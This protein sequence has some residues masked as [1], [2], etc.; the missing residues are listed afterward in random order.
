MAL[1][2]IGV[3]VGKILL[4]LVRYIYTSS[5]ASPNGKLTYGILWWNMPHN[6]YLLSLLI[7]VISGQFSF[8]RPT[9]PLVPPNTIFLFYH[10]LRFLF[11]I[12]LSP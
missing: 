5:C 3:D 11:Q 12:F 10:F 6:L 2:F 1:P 8:S 4:F 9:L 7:L